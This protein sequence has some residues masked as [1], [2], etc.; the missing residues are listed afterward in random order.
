MI[1]V[2]NL[3]QFLTH[4]KNIATRHFQFG[5]YSYY[6]LHKEFEYRW[7]GV[8]CINCVIDSKELNDSLRHFFT[9]SMT[10]DMRM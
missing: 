9:I 1:G 4:D 7:S 3:D 10:K 5:K 6:S 8:D 2:T